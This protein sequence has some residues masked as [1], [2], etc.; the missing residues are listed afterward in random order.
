M[1]YRENK[2][3]FVACIIIFFV[4]HVAQ[5]LFGVF[6]AH[7]RVNIGLPLVA[8]HSFYVDGTHLHGWYTKYAILNLVIWGGAIAIAYWLYRWILR[9]PS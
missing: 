8:Y 7:S 9:P 1:M 6:S 3:F 2:K 5:I 4:A